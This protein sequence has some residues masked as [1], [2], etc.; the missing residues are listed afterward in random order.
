MGM[1]IQMAWLAGL[2]VL[3]SCSKQPEK[4]EDTGNPINQ[5][6]LSKIETTKVVLSDQEEELLLSGKIISD[7][8]KTI[9]HVSL[10]SGVIDRSYFSIG[11]KVRKGQMLVDIRSS[12][13]SQLESERISLESAVKVAQRNLQAVQTSFNDNMASEKDLL[14]AQGQ[15]DQTQAA[16]H[17]I[18]ED[19]RLFV[20]NKGTGSFSITAPMSGY[21][22]RKNASSG[23]TV[24]SD[25]EPLFTIADLSSVWA[26]ASV[27]ASNLEFVKEGMEVFITSLSY[28]GEVFP[29]KIS[30]VSQV[31]DPDDNTL[32]ARIILPNPNLKFKPEMS[33]MIRL[34]N[35]TQQSLVSIPS[36]ALIFDNDLYYVV[37][38]EGEDRF[39][40]K[41]VQLQ[42]HH[43]KAT[44]ILSGLQE[45]EEVVCKNQ[46]LVYSGL[47]NR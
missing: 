24:T 41:E 47:K 43:G 27:Y 44:Y 45:G 46:L 38:K 30:N 12:E 37:T 14:E 42:G 29:G 16:L 21:V 36:D 17:K 2:L 1:K 13:L 8:D 33:V 35:K 39:Q 18:K 31:F 6:F 7:P 26:I 32:K 5:E 40:V 4:A 34:K 22:I 28:P 9:N 3:V 25:G 19:L 23:S 11:D 15:V 10:V 20:P